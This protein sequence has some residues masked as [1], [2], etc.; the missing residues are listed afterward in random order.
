MSWQKKAETTQKVDSKF[1]DMIVIQNHET[2]GIQYQCLRWLF[3][4]SVLFL[5]I[6]VRPS[7]AAEAE[8]QVQTFQ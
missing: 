2:N 8:S 1:K 3:L 4:E 6:H 7:T 5:D